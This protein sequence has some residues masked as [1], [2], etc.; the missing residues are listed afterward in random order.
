MGI[1]GFFGKKNLSKTALEF[2]MPDEIYAKKETFLK[3]RLINSK[4]FLPLFLM[5]VKAGEY[6]LLFP[7]VDRHTEA[8]KQIPI[9]FKNRGLAALEPISVCSVFP[10]NFFIRCRTFEDSLTALVFPEPRQCA[11]A[12][13]SGMERKT[14]GD[15][16]NNE[17]G[18]E[19]DIM[20]VREYI[21]GDPLKYIHWKAT[22]KTGKLKTKELSISA[23]Q[24]VIIDFDKIEGRDIEAQLSCAAYMVISLIR[25]GI[26]VGMKIDG[27]TFMP[28][29]S[30]QHR[31][32]ILKQ[33]AL[34]DGQ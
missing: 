30:A 18:Y 34:Y 12:A 29:I 2:E 1:S 23:H 8:V 32:N 6:E 27:K 14:K 4:G 25:K 3:V 22:A 28:E 20:S 19:S 5:K 33:L 24:P 7:F 13:V 9:V 16:Q 17:R 26:P 11:I 10:F 31:L 15:V 21:L